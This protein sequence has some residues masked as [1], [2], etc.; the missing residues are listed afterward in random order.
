MDNTSVALNDTNPGSTLNREIVALSYH[1]VRESVDYNFVK[2]RKIH[3]SN[4]LVDPFTKPLARNDF[5]G[6][7]HECMENL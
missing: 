3:T 1:L 7:Y 6:F 2:V 4:N 5:H